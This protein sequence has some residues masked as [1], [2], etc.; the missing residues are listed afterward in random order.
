MATVMFA[1][2]NT[3]SE[4]FSQMCM[5]LTLTLRKITT[6]TTMLKSRYLQEQTIVSENDNVTQLFFK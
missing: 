6:R 1:L 5:T 3:T 4:I 2:A